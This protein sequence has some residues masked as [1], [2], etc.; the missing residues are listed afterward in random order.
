MPSVPAA[1]TS[2]GGDDTIRRSIR[3]AALQGRVSSTI[4]KNEVVALGDSVDQDVLN[5]TRCR[6]PRAF[7]GPE[8]VLRQ[9]GTRGRSAARGGGDASLQ[10][11]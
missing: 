3:L 1:R 7:A 5:L 6:A 9:I 2:T 4:T 11:R 10:D 8:L